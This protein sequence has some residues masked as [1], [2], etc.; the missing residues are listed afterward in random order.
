MVSNQKIP[1]MIIDRRP[2]DVAQSFTDP[3][4]AKKIL[5]WQSKLNIV[6]MCS[7]SWNFKK[8]NLSH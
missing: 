2:G 6:D 1:Y 4:Y 8:K 3:S 5:G 7:D